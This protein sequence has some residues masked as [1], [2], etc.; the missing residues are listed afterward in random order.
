MDEG[1]CICASAEF[2]N[3]ESW[4]CPLGAYCDICETT[5]GIRPAP[6]CRALEAQGQKHRGQ[7]GHHYRPVG[8]SP[9]GPWSRIFVRTSGRPP[10]WKRRNVSSHRTQ[11]GRA[12]AAGRATPPWT[13]LL[14]GLDASLDVRPRWTYQRSCR[15]WLAKWLIFVNL[16]IQIPV[17][18]LPKSTIH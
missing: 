9:H 2:G 6:V 12:E 13:S 15:Y 3:S 16:L 4:R 8:C 5:D 7:S 11:P 10:G 17:T 14:G 18:R 1:E